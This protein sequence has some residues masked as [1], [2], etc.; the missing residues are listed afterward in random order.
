M[1]ETAPLPAARLILVLTQVGPPGSLPRCC[2]LGVR[3]GRERGKG[4]QTPDYRPP[5]HLPGLT[6][7]ATSWEQPEVWATRSR[8]PIHPHA[9]FFS[10][11]PHATHSGKELFSSTPSPDSIRDCGWSE[12]QDPTPTPSGHAGTSPLALHCDSTVAQA[13]HAWHWPLCLYTNPPPQGGPQLLWRTASIKLLTLGCID[14]RS[15]RGPSQANKEERT[16]QLVHPLA[17]PACYTRKGRE[18]DWKPTPSQTLLEVSGSPPP[19]TRSSSSL[20]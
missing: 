8:D 20:C 12:R 11:H 9:H 13:E 16:H 6:S 1:G 4:M 7:R 5:Q 10:F 18:G 17:L 3:L 14:S 15:H 19:S 2:R